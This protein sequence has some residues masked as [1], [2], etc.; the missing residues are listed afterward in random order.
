MNDNQRGYL[1]YLSEMK[2]Y[3]F[4][5][6]PYNESVDYTKYLH[7]YTDQKRNDKLLL[8]VLEQRKEL[9]AYFPSCC[10]FQLD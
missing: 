2:G 8:S 9:D 1:I 6:V 3:G 7:Y 5:A 4:S 10:T